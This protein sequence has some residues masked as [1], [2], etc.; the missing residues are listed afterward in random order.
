M[1]IN[2]S[3]SSHNSIHD[4]GDG[5]QTSNG[6]AGTFA[7]DRANGTKCAYNITQAKIDSCSKTAAANI[8]NSPPSHSNFPTRSALSIIFDAIG[9]EMV[10]LDE[11]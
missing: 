8:R 2:A 1:K 7:V 3:Q 5:A 9:K 4:D 6:T 11:K 10:N